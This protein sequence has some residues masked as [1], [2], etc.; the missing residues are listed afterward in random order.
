MAVFPILIVILPRKK[1]KAPIPLVIKKEAVCFKARMKAYI[2]DWQK[3]S[4]VKAT[5]I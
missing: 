3:V 5:W 2:A 1:M 4:P